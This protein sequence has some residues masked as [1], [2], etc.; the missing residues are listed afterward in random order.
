MELK[1]KKIVFLGDSITEGAGVADIAANRFDNRIAAKYGATAVNYGIGGTRIAHQHKASDVP[2]YDLCFC[3]RA[4]DLDKDADAI[5]VFGGTNDYGHGDA[6]FGSFADRTPATFCGAVRFLA[7]FLRENYP[8]A[9][10]VFL[11][12]SRGEGDERP[13]PDPRGQGADK[14]ALVEYVDAIARIA[15]EEGCEVLDVY[16]RLGVNPNDPAERARFT[17][18]GLHLNDAGH[19]KLAGLVGEFLETL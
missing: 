9:K 11:T 14:R 4:Y 15:G 17:A 5:V 19:G 7:A 10:V 12:P 18:D 16:R 1:G 13:D 3:G 6:D 2:R 8:K